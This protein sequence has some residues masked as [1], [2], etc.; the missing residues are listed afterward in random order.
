MRRSLSLLG[1]CAALAAVVGAAPPAAAQSDEYLATIGTAGV[2]GTA[3]DQFNDP[4]QIA[5]DANNGHILVADSANDRVQ[6]FSAADFSYIATIGE[7]NNPGSDN[8]TLFLP[9]SVAVDAAH[10]RVLVLD[11]DNVRVQIFDATSFAYQSTLG[12]VGGSAAAGTDFNF[13]A[14]IGI[15]PI[16]GRILVADTMNN[17]VQIFD[18]T[19]FTYVATLGDPNG[20]LGSDNAHLA[21]P[22]GVAFD[23]K[24]NRFL[25]AD[26]GNDRIQFFDG[27]SFAYLATLGGPELDLLSDNEHLGQTF[28]VAYDSGRDQI[29]VVD[30][31]NERVQAFDAGTLAYVGTIGTTAVAGTDNAHFQLPAGV[32]VDG[33][34][35]RIL[36]ADFLNARV[37]VFSA[38][39]PSNLDAAVLPGGRSVQL[40]NGSGTATVFATMLNS[41]SAALADCA[42]GLT[43]FQSPSI[44]AP[45][46]LSV[47][48]QTTNPATNAVTGTPDTPVAIPAGSAQTFVLTFR[49]PTAQSF[50]EQTLAFTCNGS[51]AAPI[52]YGVNTVN[53]LFSSAPVPDIIALAATPSGNGVL[54]VPFSQNG[55]AAFAVATINAGAA[56]PLTVTL[57]AGNAASLPLEAGLCQTNPTTGQCLAAPS[58]SLP[59][60]F[61]AGATATFSVF[62]KATAPV[63]FDPAGSRIFMRFFDSDGIGH[64]STSVAVTTD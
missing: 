56:S 8:A 36:V 3:N 54:T 29:L 25:V 35:G 22:Q 31:G 61:A 42:I 12:G 58:T 51:P 41:G 24:R 49:A 4:V 15:D 26:T 16:H 53:L 52:V 1:L 46:P 14:G 44:S 60:T 32:A 47:A 43:D 63:P 7:T 20:F 48:Y 13:P 33:P 23:T 37:Q 18:S 17:R 6:V 5:F 30:A 28:A 40:V 38:A 27:S 55:S 59:V 9:D 62:V 19:A 39:L 10:N 57:D 2:P 50:A 11:T 64:G 21:A 45:V 34:G